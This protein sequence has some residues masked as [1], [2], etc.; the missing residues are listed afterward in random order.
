MIKRT[1][2]Y[3]FTHQFISTTIEVSAVECFSVQLFVIFYTM[4]FLQSSKIKIF[5]NLKYLYSGKYY[6]SISSCILLYIFLFWIFLKHGNAH[7]LKQ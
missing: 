1:N 6:F 3:I 2:K 7:S 5:P 4:L